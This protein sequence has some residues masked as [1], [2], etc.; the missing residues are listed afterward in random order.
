VEEPQFRAYRKGDDD[1]IQHVISSVYAEYGFTWEP[2]GYNKDAYEIEK[3]YHEGGGGF[4]VLESDGRIVGTVG[5]KRRSAARCELYRLY[6]LRDVRG[7]GWGGLLYRK[8]QELG[9][10]MGFS[11]MEIWSDK[12]LLD[13][14]A[15]YRKSGA[16]PLGDRI[17]DDPDESEEWGFLLRL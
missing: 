3:Y 9:R 14:H 4:W 6:L 16:A 7:R 11:E 13:A 10:A 15:M 1:A 17:C 8:A 5:L 2:D 12:S